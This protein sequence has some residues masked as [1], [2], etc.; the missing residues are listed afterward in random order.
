MGNSAVFYIAAMYRN[1]ALCFVLCV[2]FWGMY[3]AMHTA[4]ALPIEDPM[5]GNE[6]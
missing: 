4:M 3:A 2:G 5:Q 1:C 6:A